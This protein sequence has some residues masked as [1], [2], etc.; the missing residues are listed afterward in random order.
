MNIRT[1]PMDEYEDSDGEDGN[2]DRRRESGEIDE[3]E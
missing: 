3:Y 1:T 2:E